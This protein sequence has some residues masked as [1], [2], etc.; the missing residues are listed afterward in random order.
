MSQETVK[1]LNTMTLIGFTEQRGHAWHYRADA[2]DGETNHYPG[3]IP[4]EDVRRGCSTGR[5]SRATSRRRATLLSDDGVGTLTITDPDRKAMLRPPGAFGPDDPGAILGIFKSGYAGHDYAQWLLEQ[6]ARSSMTSWRSARPGCCAAARWLGSRSRSPRRSR[7]PR[8][9]RFARTCSRRRALT[10][11]SRRRT[12][13]RCSSSSATTPTPSRWASP[14]SRSRSATRATRR[15]SSPTRARRSRSC[16]RSPTTS[17]PR[18]RELS[19]VQVSDGDWAR[20]LDELAPIPDRRGARTDARAVKARG[21]AAPVGPRHARRALAGHRFGVMQAVN[22][23]THHEGIVRGMARS[24]RNMLRAVTGDVDAL[25]RS[26]RR[27]RSCRSPPEQRPT[28]R[29]STASACPAATGRRRHAVALA[30]RRRSSDANRD[31]PSSTSPS[32]ARPGSTR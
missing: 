24:E 25:D 23:F 26:T 32:S 21:P 11:R 14:A 3:A 6:V 28:R 10:D 1:W 15:S 12:G 2:Q 18:S 22:T 19:A 8:A 4:V 27:R 29:T 9:S 30:I 13:A 16:T 7:L 20:F 5:C 31:R 17:P